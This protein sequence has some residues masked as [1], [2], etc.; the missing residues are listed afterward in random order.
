M[1]SPHPEEFA[2]P[3]HTPSPR[4][5]LE[6]IDS[7]RTALRKHVEA[8]AAARKSEAPQPEMLALEQERLVLQERLNARA[9]HPIETGASV[10]G[11]DGGSE[12]EKPSRPVVLSTYW[13]DRTPVTNEDY[14]LFTD[15]TG[16]RKPAHWQGRAYPLEKANHPVT[17]VSWND[18]VAYSTWACKRLP[19]EAEWEKAARGTLGQRFPWGD[20]PPDDRLN[21]G[22]EG[23]GTTD[24]RRFETGA[25]PY[26]LLD[27]SGNVL[28]WC[29]D[30]FSDAYYG[31]APGTDPPGPSD[32]Q[33]RIVRGGFFGSNA[34]GVRCAARHWAPPGKPQRHIGFRCACSP[35]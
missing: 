33:Y 27:M 13:I 28:E 20:G 8:V 10:M 15:A 24:V 25:S 34:E 22:D 5:R 9:M 16:H 6:A 23:G 30:W 18:A 14:K 11:D 19:A 7:A 3:S 4:A 2:M 26:G 35:K 29:S 21:Y 1:P 12:N 31:Y 32:G 17:H